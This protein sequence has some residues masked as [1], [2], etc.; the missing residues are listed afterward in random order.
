MA[1]SAVVTKRPSRGRGVPTKQLDALE[2]AALQEK[3]LFATRAL[4]SER[5]EEGREYPR[6]ILGV[7]LR[8]YYQLDFSA[9]SDLA[10][11]STLKN[12]SDADAQE[13]LEAAFDHIDHLKTVVARLR[14]EVPLR[15]DEFRVF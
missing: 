6:I 2:K 4:H 15:K 3:G 7:G 1:R 5:D 14:E 10:D 11:G 9:L 12:L 13:L 8:Y